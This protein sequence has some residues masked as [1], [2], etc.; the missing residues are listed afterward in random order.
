[1][2]GILHF[3]RIYIFWLKVCQKVGI[4]IENLKNL[5]GCDTPGSTPLLEVVTTCRTC[6]LPQHSRF[7]RARGQAP[8]CWYTNCDGVGRPV[9]LI[10]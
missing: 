10:M 9:F 8:P 6:D 2:C 5:S 3:R 4:C 1:M 7:G